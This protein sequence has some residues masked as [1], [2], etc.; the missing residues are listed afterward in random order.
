MID[1]RANQAPNCPAMLS[2]APALAPS[3]HASD[4][5]IGV[6]SSPPAANY[7][8]Y[9]AA[10][11]PDPMLMIVVTGTGLTLNGCDGIYVDPPS[12]A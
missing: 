7:V 4:W 12:I 2:T 6:D 5:P 10:G 9:R 1:G 11:R 3:N 8:K